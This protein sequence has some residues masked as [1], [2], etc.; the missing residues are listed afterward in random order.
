MGRLA[1]EHVKALN[2]IDIEFH[3]E[4]R[5]KSILEAWKAY[6][7]QL[8]NSVPPDS[9]GAFETWL[10]KRD[11]LLVDLLYAMSLSLGYKYDK[12]FIRRTVYSP[13]GFFEIEADGYAIRKH[14]LQILQGERPL[15]ISVLPTPTTHYSPTRNIP[16]DLTLKKAQLASPDEETPSVQD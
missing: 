14:T 1:P 13:Q 11:D 16:E 3:G 10:S 4:K 5:S 7:D 12:T 15:Q 2:M 8:N 9:L 6:L